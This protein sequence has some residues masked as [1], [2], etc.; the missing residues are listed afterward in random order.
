MCFRKKR[1]PFPEEKLKATS[2]QEMFAKMAPSQEEYAHAT[3][4]LSDFQSLNLSE[5]ST[6][7]LELDKHIV[8]IAGG[9]IVVLVTFLGIIEVGNLPSLSQKA[10]GLFAIWALALSIVGI[11][12]SYIAS[13]RTSKLNLEAHGTSDGIYNLMR[14]TKAK[15]A[16]FWEKANQQKNRFCDLIISARWWNAVVGKSNLTAQVLFVVGILSLT[17]FGTINLL[18]LSHG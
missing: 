18:E 4:W 6:N 7:S 15:D 3:G 2:I 13:V 12:F 14:V 16:A 9:A 11:V 17:L 10:L 5:L 8:T 1:E